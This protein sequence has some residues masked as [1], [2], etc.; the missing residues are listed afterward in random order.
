[1]SRHMSYH[2]M[3]AFFSVSSDKTNIKT[4]TVR[5]NSFHLNSQKLYKVFVSFLNLKFLHTHKVKVTW[6]AIFNI[7]LLVSSNLA[8]RSVGQ[9]TKCSTLVNIS[10][11]STCTFVLRLNA[12]ILNDVYTLL[13]SCI[14]YGSYNKL[15]LSSCTTWKYSSSSYKALQ[16][17]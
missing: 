4:K 17:I 13:F 9:L 2:N 11:S 15:E 5:F 16:P 10:V 1:M 7:L 14:P 6:F 3:S 8:P 12:N